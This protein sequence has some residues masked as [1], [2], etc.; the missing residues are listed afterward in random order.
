VRAVV[1][2]A[3]M[4]A[5]L[6]R[7]TSFPDAREAFDL[8][9][10]RDSALFDSF[11][12]GYQLAA[13]GAVERAEVMTEFR[14]A[15]LFVHEQATQGQF[16]ITDQD[17][18]RAMAPFDGLV[19]FSVEARLHPLHTYA[20]PPRYELYVETSPRTPPLAA[21]PLR[22]SAVYPPGMMGPGDPMS[23]VRLEGTFPRIDIM[24]AAA[25]TIVVMDDQANVIWK[26]RIDLSRYR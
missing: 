3:L 7:Q 21:K 19:T 8:G 22:R 10:T 25:P 1:L 15:V 9:R 26:A 23:G 20:K 4:L 11:N 2:V 16:L 17:L 14:R 24:S 5:A 13:S 18:A 12:R 6:A